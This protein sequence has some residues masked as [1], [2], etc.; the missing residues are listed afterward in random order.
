MEKKLI[1]LWL[2]LLYGEGT[3]IYGRLMTYFETEQ[4]IYDCDDNDVAS[5]QWLTDSQKR[6]LLDKNMEHAEEVWE[7]CLENDVEIIA[8]SDDKYPQSLRCIEKFP[9]I[10]YCKG[11]LPN[12]NE[13]LSVS[14]VGT[15]S[16]SSYGQK[17]AFELG[18]TLSKGGAITVSGMARGI[19]ATVAHGTINALGTTV[20]VLGSGIDI[21]Y[22]RENTA[23]MNQII[24]CGAVITEFPPHT[25]PNG[26]NFPIRNRIISGISNAT[27]IVEG[28]ENSGAMITARLAM[29]QQKLLFAVPGPVGVHTS[30]GTNMLLKEEK[31]LV[32][33]YATDVFAEFLK[34]YSDKIDLTKAKQRPSFIQRRKA[35]PDNSVDHAKKAK[36]IRKNVIETVKKFE[37]VF[38]D[39]EEKVDLSELSE[40]QLKIYNSMKKEETYSVDQLVALTGLSAS[41]V[42]S[43]VSYLQIINRITEFEG[44]LYA[45]I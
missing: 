23:L 34:D 15:R 36:E 42:M 40:V 13:E 1:W 22:P 2:S 10:L 19:D 45:K 3:D 29:Q 21:V 5:I 39:S 4:D 7:W 27:V 28:D 20:A 31:A 35:I 32:A 37:E 44:S 24:D 6:K 38:N 16:M 33:R 9:A 41:E 30:K 17:I 11:K 43:N 18:Y 12:F 14:V 25:P 8:Y 26:R